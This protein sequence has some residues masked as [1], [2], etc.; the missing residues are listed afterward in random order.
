MVAAIRVHEH[1]GPEVL[2]FED[3]AVK[4]P[5]PGEL[6]MK[7]NAIGLNFIDTYY[8]TGLYKAPAMPFSPGNEAAGVVTAVGPGVSGFKAGDRVAYYGPLGAYTAERI[9]PAERV[10]KLPD[11]IDDKTAAGMML[12]GMTAC[13]LVK[14]TFKVERGQNV[15]IH[16]A[17][18][19]T[20][21]LL[22]QW[23][24]HLGAN[25]I[26]TVGSK[27]KAKLAQDH[28]CK[29]TIIYTEEDFVARVGEITKGAKCEV[30]YD[31]V[32][33][34]T[35][36]GSLDC[37]KNFGMFV[38]FGNASGAIENFS[39][40]LLSQK[41][42]LYATRPTLVTHA[43][44]REN[45]I[46]LA[47]DLFDVV[48]KGAVKIEVRQTYALKDAA[49]AHRDLESRKTTGSSVLIP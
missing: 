16:A 28:G 9:V 7:Q 43:A 19:A 8:R 15:L 4:D 26:G 49:H 38:S 47:N 34:A 46:A 21:L 11:N 37:L 36:P 18:G 17:A 39:I 20:G 30:V 6:R 25:V 31:G 14:R 29:H 3:V 1:G 5:G 48:G 33:K 45:L 23:A 2:K 32:G 35:Y 44:K 13:Y 27:E 12:K 42:S 10:I 22:V 41:G 40:L 24:A